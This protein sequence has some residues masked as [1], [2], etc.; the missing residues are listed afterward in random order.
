MKQKEYAIIDVETTGGKA[1]RCR[2]TE[3]GI[4]IFDGEKVVET[5]ESLINP[6]TWIP[7]GIV[8]LTGITQEMVKTAP[9]FHEVA[10]RIIELTEDRIF[11][12][13]NSRFD[14]DF[15]KEEFRRLGY[16]YTRKQLCTVRLTRK[17]YPGLPWPT[18]RRPPNYLSFA[19]LVLILLLKY[20]HSSIGEYRQLSCRRTC[21][22]S[23]S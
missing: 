2:I 17:T 3:I 6:E 12:A 4:V 21:S 23:R 16:T 5:Y 14:Y 10:R 13:H 8:E 15:V 22:W 9:K 19:L 1:S 20:K 11:V 18:R 7:A